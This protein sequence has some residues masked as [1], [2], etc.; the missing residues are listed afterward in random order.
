MRFARRNTP[1]PTNAPATPMENISA[2]RVVRPP[3][4]RN[5]AWSTR[6]ILATT[7]VSEGPIR[8][9]AMPVAQGCEQVPAVGTGIGMH[10]ITKTAAPT[11]PTNGLIYGSFSLRTRR[12]LN[13]QNTNGT[14]STNQNAAH[15][16]GKMPSEICIA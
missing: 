16:R 14:L 9:A 11:S 6:A 12:V 7:T 2:P 1:Y 3:C 13:P 5:N 10:E 4:A 15:G 8:M